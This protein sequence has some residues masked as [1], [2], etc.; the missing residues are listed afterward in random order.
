MIDTTTPARPAILDLVPGWLVR[1]GAIG[2]RVLAALL[3]G[4]VAIELA[5]ALSTVTVSV[6]VAVVVAATFAPFVMRLR[7]RGWSRTRA[8]AV[9]TVGAVAVILVT[10]VLI[11]LSFAPYIG[12]MRAAIESGLVALRDR[13]AEVSIP[14]EVADA[15]AKAEAGLDA[16]LS[17][18]AGGIASTIANVATVGVLA[19]FTTF[20]LLQDGDKAWVWAMRSASDWRRETITSSGHVALERVGGYLRGTAVLAAS[21]A[22]SDFIFLWLLGVP[23]AGPLSVLVFFG[24][25]IPYIGGLIT[26]TII[27]LVT[28]AS[29]GVG[30]VVILLV[31]IT[32]MNIVQGNIM[33]PV[34]YGK[35]VEIHPALVLVALPAGAAFFG[36]IGLFAAIPI[37]AFVLA[38]VGA[39]VTALGVDPEAERPPARVSGDSAF[40]PVWLDRLGQWSWRLLVGAAL[41]YAAIT[42]LVQVPSVIL[43][44][45]LGVV[46]ASTLA[47]P[48]AA[49]RRRG[50]GR[51]RA[52][53]AATAGATLV[54]VL[55]V[56]VTVASLIGPLRQVIDQAIAGAGDADASASGILGLLVSVV[57]EYGGAL[58]AAVAGAVAG[59]AGLAVIL[60]LSVFLT[61]YFLRDG[62]RFWARVLERVQA[63]R[64]ARVAEAGSRAV[65]V[66]GGYMVGTGAISLFGALTQYVIMVIL[67]IPLALPLAVLSFFGGFI[68]YIGSFLT[69]GLALLVTIAVGSPTDV[70]V[71]VAFTLI[72]NVVQGNFVAPIVYSRVVS[73]HPA[74]VLLAIPAGNDLAGIAGM[75]LIVP[76]LGVVAATWRSGLHLLDIDVGDRSRGD[77]ATQTPMAPGTAA[78]PEIGTG[79]AD[80]PPPAPSPAPG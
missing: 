29:Q 59:L 45:I 8:A 28:L 78:A 57:E 68:P 20:F 52:A 75:F 17:E 73:L 26:T 42:A 36:I 6:L 12:D 25:F 70:I 18:A 50:W 77:A 49:L 63:S 55:V 74:V 15:I 46:F 10:L 54:V 11:G 32:V 19:S 47:R 7:D 30:A 60:F 35:T 67:G 5:I 24:G 53:A 31:L 38:I 40:V 61:F 41:I 33:A 2:W 56:A 13:L 51:S 48:V 76:F 27:V 39:L 22:I 1:L 71:M 65:D 9:V 58:I 80:G 44:V 66:L 34:I 72:F 3:V 37:V 4:L 69:T 43:P 21:D 62:D 14:P 23:L 79:A 64:R 16:W